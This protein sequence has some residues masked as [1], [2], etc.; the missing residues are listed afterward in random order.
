MTEQ[1]GGILFVDIET[2][3]VQPAFTQ[4][5]ESMQAEWERKARLIKNTGDTLA[6]ELFEARAGVYSEFAKIICIGFGSMYNASGQWKLR[7][8]TIS[9][10]NEHEVLTAFVRV[11]DRITAMHGDVRFCGHNIREFDIP[12]ICRRL[13]INGIP[14]PTCLRLSGKKPWEIHHIDT[15]ELWKFGDNKNYTS[16]SLLACVLGIPSPKGDID[17]S[18]VA[19]VYWRD[20]DL[21]RIARYCTGDVLTSA[22][23][24]LRLRGGDHIDLIPDYADGGQG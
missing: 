16:L 12:F 4:L 20:G 15:L 8:K 6:G 11:V 9:G 22:R 17:G 2:V 5:S 13:V 18:Q 7:L 24:W 10:H 14:L 21:E 3:P 1:F 23:V 19:D